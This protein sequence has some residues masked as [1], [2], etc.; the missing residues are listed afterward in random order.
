MKCDMEEEAFILLESLAFS[1]KNSTHHDIEKEEE[2]E[3]EE[4]KE[5]DMPFNSL[6]LPIH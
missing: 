5:G 3:E 1:M 6:L 4:D 2:E